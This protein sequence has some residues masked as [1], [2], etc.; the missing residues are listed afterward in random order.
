MKLKFE[1]GP[2][3]L[4]PFRVEPVKE[5]PIVE[6][7]CLLKMLFPRLV[8]LNEVTCQPQVLLEIINVKLYRDCRVNAVSGLL[9]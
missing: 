6:C 5:R 7:D 3:L 9:G 2:Q 8:T 1:I 4:A